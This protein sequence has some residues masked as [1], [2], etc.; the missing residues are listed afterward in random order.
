LNE[1]EEILQ[2]AERLAEWRGKVSA[3]LELVSAALNDLEKTY[4]TFVEKNRDELGAIKSSFDLG[5]S[6]IVKE[7]REEARSAREEHL[8]ESKK[9]HEERAKELKDIKD[10]VEALNV[11]ITN[12]YIKVAGIGATTGALVWILRDVVLKK[13]F[14]G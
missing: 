14:G 4:S 1:H 13:F 12:L 6:S 7:L 5:L 2:R 10:Q 8:R 9:Y 11:R 3:T